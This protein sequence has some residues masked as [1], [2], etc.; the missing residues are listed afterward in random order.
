M[1]KIEIHNLKEIE[2]NFESLIDLIWC[3]LFFN[4]I[5]K[6]WTFYSQIKSIHEF[7]NTIWIAAEG[8][9]SLIAVSNSKEIGF[10]SDI[11]GPISNF[12]KNI[13]IY[14]NEFPTELNSFNI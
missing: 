5:H 2:E 6:K 12:I 7:N 1:I 8:T 10:S 4:N 9:T 11:W 14:K 13:V 3:K